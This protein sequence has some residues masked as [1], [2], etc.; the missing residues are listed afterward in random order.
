MIYRLGES[1]PEFE[2]EG[3]FVAPDANVIGNVRLGARSSIWFGA[4][5]RGDNDWINIGADS[6]IQ[7][8]SVVHTDPGLPVQIGSGVTVG[9][10][11]MLHGC[12]VG[13][14]SLIGIGS[15]VLNRANIGK[16]CLVGAHSLVTEGKQFPDGVLIL[17]SPARVIRELNDDEVA[18]LVASAASYTANSRRF[19]EQLAEAP[20]STDH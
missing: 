13:D 3:H 17:G 4:T 15:S 18:M 10:R 11:V 19:R 1:S 5:V 2:G 9:H 16:R 20:R 8:A 6:N 14:G 12:T 7:D